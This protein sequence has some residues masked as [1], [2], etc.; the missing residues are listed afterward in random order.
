MYSVKMMLFVVILE[1]I[2]ALSNA[3]LADYLNNPT[4]SSETIGQLF[5]KEKLKEFRTHAADEKNLI[6]FLKDLNLFLETSHE[7]NLMLK[8]EVKDL[9]NELDL[10][11]E[12]I[13]KGYDFSLKKHPEKEIRDL[14]FTCQT[15]MVSALQWI[16]M[17][18]KS[19]KDERINKL[20]SSIKDNLYSTMVN[21]NSITSLAVKNVKD[22]HNMILNLKSTP[23]E[24][25]SAYNE[26]KDEINS[27]LFI[28]NTEKALNSLKELF[29]NKKPESKFKF[30][31][32]FVNIIK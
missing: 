26:S 23:N 3:N 11:V 24:I 17:R 32:V 6:P 5:T 9:L 31:D 8:D 27:K 19:V 16:A 30:A 29:K 28:D 13:K 1:S 20:L 10:V 18:M 7:T 2:L 22:I 14:N 15:N 4:L 21:L 12:L 25:E